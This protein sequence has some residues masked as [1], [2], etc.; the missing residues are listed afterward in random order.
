MIQRKTIFC[1]CILVFVVVFVLP[2]MLVYAGGNKALRNKLDE[3]NG[4]V[5]ELESE[6]SKLKSDVSSL[7]SKVSSLEAERDRLRSQ[8]AELESEI[9]TKEAE[10]EMLQAQLE[11]APDPMIVA[12][13]IEQK[14]QEKEAEIIELEMEKDELETE[15]AQTNRELAQTERELAQA[16]KELAEL[17]SENR[18]MQRQNER[19]SLQVKDL[20]AE[21]D[22]LL[23]VLEVYEGIERESVELMDI[24]L[25]RINELLYEEIRDGKV[26][27]FKGTLGIVLDVVS[28]HMFDVG[29]V[30]INEGGRQILGKIG[31]LLGEIDGYLI[32]VIGNADSKPIVTPSLKKQFPTNWELS[33]ARGATVVRYFIDVSGVS[34]TRFIS[35]GLGEF[36]PID[37]NLTIEGRGNNRRV[38]LVLLPMDVL[39]AVIVGA[40]IK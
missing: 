7:E 2:S 21:N 9:A 31:T 8:I 12:K 16:N 1:V 10:I 34:P 20:E 29:S 24:I 30:E 19:L 15:I 14:V 38:D 26:R 35:M 13:T 6:T 28:E 40:E 27:V 11:E 33:A 5:E 36:Q 17:R 39:A 22:E 23:E 37:T 18:T 32:G 3:C 4:K 25:E